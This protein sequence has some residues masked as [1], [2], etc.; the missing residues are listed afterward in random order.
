MTATAVQTSGLADASS[1]RDHMIQ[2]DGLRTVAI[3]LVLVEHLVPIHRLLV[4]WFPS[5][6]GL[7]PNQVTPPLG[8]VGVSLFFVISGFLITRILLGSRQRMDSGLSTLGR[9]TRIF[10][11]RRTLRIFPLYYGTL[12]VLW[13]LDVRQ[14]HDRIGWHLTYTFNWLFSIPEH[15]G[16]GGYERHF[17]SLGVEEQFYLLWPWLILLV[18]RRLLL[19]GLLATFAIGPLWRAAFHFRIWH[20]QDQVPVHGLLDGLGWQFTTFTTPA[21]L[22]LL[23]AGALVAYFWNTPLRR[24]VLWA[25]LLVGLPAASM[26]MGLYR[27]DWLIDQRHVFNQ[28]ALALCFAAFVGFAGQGIPLIGRALAFGPIAYLGKISYGMYVFHNFTPPMLRWATGVEGYGPRPWLFA[29]TCIAL[30]IAMAAISWHLFEYPINRL[31]N[32]FPYTRREAG[33]GTD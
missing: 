30:T 1:R 23:A 32:R 29:F 17:W 21:C 19:P 12:L 7:R 15:Y 18:P 16:R 28:T 10:Y 4:E 3:G 6:R 20:W 8:F 26:A 22:D 11:I 31:K 5:L 9:E 27:S 25:C 14:I 13:L 33:G 24:P 2:I